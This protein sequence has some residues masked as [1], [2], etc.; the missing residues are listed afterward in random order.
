MDATLVRIRLIEQHRRKNWRE[1]SYDDVQRFL[2]HLFGQRKRNSQSGIFVSKDE[3]GRLHVDFRGQIEI[4]RV[5][6]ADKA[7]RA[8]PAWLSEYADGLNAD[9]RSS[10][11]RAVA[12]LR[13]VRHDK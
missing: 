9:I 3:R 2:V 5:I 11:E 7:K 12:R 8:V 4:E 13:P 6:V 10:Y 1:L